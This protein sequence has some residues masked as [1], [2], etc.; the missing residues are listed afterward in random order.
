MIL[1]ELNVWHSRPAVPTRR[2]ALGEDQLKFEPQ[3]GPGGL[4][5]G[6]VVA[7]YAQQ[8][9]DEENND[10]TALLNLLEVGA[11]IPQPRLRHRLQ[12]D[13]IGLT[14]ST[15][16][17]VTAT[18]GRMS[19]DLAPGDRPEPHI[20]AALYRAS[21]QP[22]DTRRALLTLLRSARRWQG[23]DHDDLLRYLSG[24]LPKGTWDSRV[25]VD[26]IVWALGILG[27]PQQQTE[28]LPDSRL[29]RRTFRRLLRNAHPDHGG[30]AEDAGSRIETL[31]A[32]RNILLD[33]RSA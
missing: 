3:P 12:R 20:L 16:R 30:S 29:V 9:G 23:H 26:P 11:R 8:L 2:V 18:N 13:R 31:T 32:A 6:A 33:R 7:V 27:F 28:N 5:L 21:D 10:L 1:A 19:L 4:L 24:D 15:H 22:G 17:L 25:D 14:R